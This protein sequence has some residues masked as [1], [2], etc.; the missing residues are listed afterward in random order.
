MCQR[1]MLAYANSSSHL[2]LYVQGTWRTTFHGS[3]GQLICL[4]LLELNT[5]HLHFPCAF[6]VIDLPLHLLPT[7]VPSVFQVREVGVVVCVWEMV[8]CQLTHDLGKNVDP[9][10]HLCM[11]QIVV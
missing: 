5:M 6:M 2:I 8:A 1:N 7:V 9:K 10:T 4:I 3:T 11:S